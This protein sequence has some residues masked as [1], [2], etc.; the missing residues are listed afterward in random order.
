MIDC[1]VELDNA[2]KG[3]LKLLKVVVQEQTGMKEDLLLTSRNF[4]QLNEGPDEKVHNFVSA[5]KKLFKNAYPI[6]AI[7]SII[8]LQ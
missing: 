2:T 7:T 8:L 5:L 3:D 1:H 4:N 6:E